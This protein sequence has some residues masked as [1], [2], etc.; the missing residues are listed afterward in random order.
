MQK[1]FGDGINP[2]IFEHFTQTKMKRVSCNRRNNLPGINI[3]GIGSIL[4]RMKKDDIVFG[5]GI[6]KDD[7]LPKSDNVSDK[8]ISVRGPLTRN[9]IINMGYQCNEL[10]G[11]AALL[12]PFI[13]PKPNVEIKYKIGIIPHYIDQNNPFL[14]KLY[15]NEN[16]IFIDILSSDAPNTFVKNISSCDILFSSS[17]HGVIVG[18]A[19]GIKS[20]HLHISNKVIGDN[21]KFKDYYQSINR[22]YSN[23]KLN[24]KINLESLID[25]DKKCPYTRKLNIRSLI[26]KFPFIHDDVKND[27]IKKIENGLMDHFGSF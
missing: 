18:D 1:N 3:L 20:H 21:F 7:A 12:L 6:I 24:E 11:D 13:I 8:I 9:K 4:D 2:L 26:E 15:E 19:Y 25:F 14:K 16:I 17:L 22:Q 27:S 23:I 10:Y 5:S